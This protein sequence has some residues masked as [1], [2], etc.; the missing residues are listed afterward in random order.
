[1]KKNKTEA[2]IKK[3]KNLG[4]YPSIR[5]DLS[6]FT[7]SSLSQA[8]LV[9]LK[10]I[11]G[12]GYNALGAFG[13]GRDIYSLVNE[14][15]LRHKLTH[16]LKSDANRKVDIALKK[17][18]SIYKSNIL[19]LS[20]I[21]TTLKNK[22][23]FQTLELLYKYSIDIHFAIAIYNCFFRFFQNKSN[24]ISSK[25]V[26]RIGEERNEVA[27]QYVLFEKLL[28][29]AAQ[30]LSIKNKFNGDALCYLIRKEFLQFLRSKLSMKQVMSLYQVRKKKYFFMHD[31]KKEHVLY[32]SGDL[33]KIHNYLWPK[34]GLVDELKG[35]SIY[36][37]NVTAKAYLIGNTVRRNLP[38][39]K[40]IIVASMTHPDLMPLLK[41]SVG[42]ITDEG[43]ILC[44]AAIIARELRK[45]CII[46]TKFAT[47]VFKDG[48]I[49]EVDADKGIIKKVK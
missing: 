24:V 3:F 16:Y 25:M 38:T 13:K 15:D 40:Y 26:V 20:V 12:F 2:I 42:I 31:G 37:G 29:K 1:M 10:E 43:G 41:K 33:N 32:K 4:L 46:G 21:E 17:A 28:S 14:D 18:Y 30:G 22:N 9:R 5:R 49:V 44:H 11:F 23:Y 19:H 39:Y 36:K 45:P 48:D 6:L 34:V 35:I 7:M 8:Y 27:K 47:K